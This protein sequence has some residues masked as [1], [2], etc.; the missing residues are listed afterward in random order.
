[1]INGISITG[2]NPGDFAQIPSCGSS[3]P[4]KQS[5]TISVT[6][7]PTTTGVRNASLAV[8]DNGG[9]SPQNVPLNGTGQ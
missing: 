4:P 1:M 2:T 6:F 7:S 5:C 9:G 8:S 3:L